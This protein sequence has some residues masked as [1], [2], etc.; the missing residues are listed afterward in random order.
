[1]TET[2][3]LFP[4]SLKQEVPINITSELKERFDSVIKALGD[5]CELS[6]KQPIPG[7]QLVLITD[8]SFRRAE[9]APMFEDKPDQKTE[10]KGKTYAPAAFGSK[11]FP[12][13][14]LKKS[15]YLKESLV[16]NLDFPE[17]AH[18]SKGTKKRESLTDNKSVTR[19]FQATAIPPAQQNPCEYVLQII[20][21]IAHIAGSVNT[22]AD[23]LFR[24]LLRVME[25]LCLKSLEDIQNN[26]HR[27][28]NN[29]LGCH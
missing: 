7:K 22:A 1:M 10:S 19:F 29:L 25:K 26:T 5:A 17:F 6:L 2:L 3:N 13:P 18:I 20:F 24:L 16:N 4:K 23:F 28:D 11:F 8:V 14:Q 12:T 27:G 9:Y 21:K 15:T